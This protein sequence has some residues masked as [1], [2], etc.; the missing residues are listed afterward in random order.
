[1]YIYFLNIQSHDENL[2]YKIQFPTL[3]SSVFEVFS[4]CCLKVRRK[5][6]LRK[7]YQYGF[8]LILHVSL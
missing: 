5:Q 6:G 1:M 2:D 7:G 8:S 4:N 3:G